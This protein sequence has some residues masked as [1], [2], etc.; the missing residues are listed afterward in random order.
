MSKFDSLS[1]LLN[2]LKAKGAVFSLTDDKFSV[3]APR[4]V[5]S[6]N[7][8]TYLAERR[9]AV[10]HCLENQRSVRMWLAARMTEFRFPLDLPPEFE[11]PFEDAIVSF[12]D[13]VI[14]FSQ[15]EA[16][17]HQFLIDVHAERDIVEVEL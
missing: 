12:V 17:W 15:L 10:K 1:T 8:K 7:L 4:G 6:S 13:G 2:G 9:E 5:I 11:G 16:A 14:D 3:R